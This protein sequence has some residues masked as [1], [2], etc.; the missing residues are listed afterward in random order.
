MMTKVSFLDKIKILGD[1]ISSSNLFIIAIL[2][3]III[4]FLFVTTNKSN[5]KS[6]KTV[7]ILIYAAIIIF[8]M[9]TYHTSLGN[10]ID[11]MMNNFF[12]AIYFPNLAIYLAA[13]IIT[14]IITWTSIFDF[15]I[16]KIQ[17]ILNTI[18]F[19]LMHYLLILILHIITEKGLDVFTQ[20]SVYGNGQALALIELS[21]TIFIVWIIF[22]LL[23]KM[24]RKYFLNKDKNMVVEKEKNN[25][26][27]NINKIK[28][29]YIIKKD[30]N[31]NTNTNKKTN[32]EIF[33]NLLTI[34]DY[35]LLLNIL[36]EHKIKEQEEQERKRKELEEQNKYIELQA[37]Y[38]N[39]DR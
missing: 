15:K 22:I 2:L 39:I 10:M 12:I 16:D 19:C 36:K 9:I 8:I 14:N 6:S 24:I 37:L 13:I 1:V 23:Y 4:G 7:Y 29:P 25:A 11:Y 17:K 20:S 21:S 35:K 34:D 26:L 3:F 5:E 31:Q 27:N 33:D 18:V 38:K 30:I 28:Y 32:N